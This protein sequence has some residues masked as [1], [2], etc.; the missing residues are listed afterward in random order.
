MIADG[1]ITIRFGPWERFFTGHAR[2]AL[3]VAAVRQAVSTDRPLSVPRGPRRGLLVSGHT[4][5]GVWG[6]YRGP[7]QLVSVNRR[8]P[9][10]HL[11]L[12]RSISGGEI[13]EVV[14]SVSD[15]DRLVHA[16]RAVS[17]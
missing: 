11:L 2:Y 10:L 16:I 3:P 7:R 6:I 1:V 13:D 5:I 4:K 8:L 15:A 17:A 12:D 14:V 9:G